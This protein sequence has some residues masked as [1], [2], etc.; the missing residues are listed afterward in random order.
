MRSSTLVAL[1]ANTVLIA[2]CIAVSDAAWLTVCGCSGHVHALE[3]TAMRVATLA[4]ALGIVIVVRRI[5]KLAFDAA[6]TAHRIAW[7][8]DRLVIDGSC[9]GGWLVQ[10]HVELHPAGSRLSAAR[11]CPRTAASARVPRGRE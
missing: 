2:L 5:A 6:R 8:A 11:D 3:H 1:R 9:P 4:S 7:A 10:L